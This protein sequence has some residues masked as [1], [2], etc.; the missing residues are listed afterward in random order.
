M[1]LNVQP[2]LRKMAIVD[3]KNVYGNQGVARTQRPLL[4][5]FTNTL[6]LHINKYHLI[7]A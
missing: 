3:L 7:H 2:I 5:H 1:L 6:D 4:M